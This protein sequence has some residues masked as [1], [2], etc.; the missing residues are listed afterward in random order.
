MN[1]IDG[2]EADAQVF[3]KVLVGRDVAAPALQA[4]LHVEL[5]AFADGG[6]VHVLVENFDVA[7]GLDHPRG[8]YPGLVGA[9]INGL[10]TIAVQLERNLLEVEDDV[11]GV[12]NH[13]LY[14]LEL[15]QHALNLDRGD[16]SALDRGQQHA[17]QRIADRSAES[18]LE[19]LRLKAAEPVGKC[20]GLGGQSFGFL[21]TFPK[22]RLRFSFR[23]CGSRSH[24]AGP[25]AGCARPRLLGLEKLGRKNQ[26]SVV[27]CQSRT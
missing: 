5:A 10:G 27:S 26:L 3:V 1:R 17:P 4:H 12:F 22:H 7:I 24:P 23:P 13:A 9:Q 6:D 16:G 20:L 21:K 18:A 25:S 19:R 8:D 15:V 14:G 2:N 11:S